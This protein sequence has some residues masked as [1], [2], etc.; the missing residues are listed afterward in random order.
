M[1][2]GAGIEFNGSTT[3]R[4]IFNGHTATPGTFRLNNSI[5]F[6]DDTTINITGAGMERWVASSV[7][8]A[9]GKTLTNTGTFRTHNACNM[10]GQFVSDGTWLDL[11]GSNLLNA[12]IT[13][14]SLFSRFGSHPLQPATGSGPHRFVNNGTFESPTGVPRNDISFIEFQNTGTVRNLASQGMVFTA[15]AI[16]STPTAQWHVVH[17]ENVTAGF[18]I[19]D[20]SIQ[21]TFAGSTIDLTDWRSTSRSP[22]ST[23]PPSTSP[24]AASPAG[25]PPHATSPRESPSSTRAS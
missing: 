15:C 8:V 5:H 25:S 1:G 14:N 3:L 10:S 2:A 12:V 17:G 6:A 20:C 19:I 13:N 24:A 21:G 9:P 18:E 11:G 7:V 23:T 22:L 4:G 16:T